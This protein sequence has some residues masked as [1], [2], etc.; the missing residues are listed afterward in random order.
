[1]YAVSDNVA[2]VR[3]MSIPVCYGLG[4]ELQLCEIWLAAN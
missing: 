4:A 1:M 2:M 3:P